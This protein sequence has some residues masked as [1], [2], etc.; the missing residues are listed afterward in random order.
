MTARRP[1]MAGNWKMNGTVAESA[2]LARAMR[3]V[4]LDLPAVDVAVFP[5]FLS[6]GAVVEALRGTDVAVGGQDV[7]FAVGGAHTGDTS[8]E[9]LR[10]AGCR[11]ALVGHSERRTNHDESGELLAS[12][13]KGALR[14]ELTPIFCCG[15]TL[16]QRES[17][18]ALDVVRTQLTEG[19]GWLTASGAERV[20]VAYEPV[21]A[22][23]TGKTASPEQAQ[24][25]HAAIRAW[26]GT[27]WNAG[28]GRAV[29]ILYGGS[30]K[31]GNV[32]GIMAQ[33]DIDGALVGGASLKAESFEAIVR[34]QSDHASR[35]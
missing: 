17:G 31:P 27:Q 1:L 21:W 18:R 12:K 20:V 13:V 11:M 3:S 9:M 29:R 4:L 16:E 22:I 7:H 5:P 10:G 19:L 35:G 6:I 24:E 33:V 34:F 23:G 15:E 8:A 2:E 14:A 26:I 32:A 28:T 25:V 30:I